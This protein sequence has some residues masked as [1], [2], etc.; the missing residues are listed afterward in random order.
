MIRNEPVQSPQPAT[1]AGLPV[2][3]W[4]DLS[5]HASA[6]ECPKD[7][8][9]DV[10]LEAVTKVPPD[11]PAIARQ[12]NVDG[13]V[14]M[15]VLVCEHG[16]VADARITRSVAMLDHAALVAISQWKFRPAMFEDKPVP[17]WTVIPMR[18]TLN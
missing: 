14:V 15:S 3:K 7:L 12:S 10:R 5:D 9:A 18:F 1:A 4:C 2:P 16:R 17:A 11:Y 8:T 6:P 13:T